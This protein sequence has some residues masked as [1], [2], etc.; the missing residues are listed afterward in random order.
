MSESWK[1]MQTVNGA[2]ADGTGLAPVPDRRHEGELLERSG[3]AL[4]GHKAVILRN[5]GLLTVGDTVDAA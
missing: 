3:P 1:E 5:H 2:D 4:G